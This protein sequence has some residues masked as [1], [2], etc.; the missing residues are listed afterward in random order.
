M[1]SSGPLLNHYSFQERREVLPFVPPGAHKILD[2]GCAR[3]G[4]GSALRDGSARQVFGVEPNPEAADAAAPHYES[5]YRGT[6]PEAVPEAERFDCVI[7]L[8]VLEHLTDPYATVRA[9]RDMLLP[10]GTV[11]AS[12]PNV[13]HASVLRRLLVHADWTYQDEGILDWTH[14]RFFTH[15]TMRSLFEDNGF[16]V[17]V[18]APINQSQNLAGRVLR[19]LPPVRDMA[20]VQFVVVARPV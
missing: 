11:L 9:S 19:R 6:F 5:V 13:R 15:K 4:F 20:A 16:R 17:E 18:L 2:V 10:G 8:D 7:F 14:L 1:S 12:L 3:G